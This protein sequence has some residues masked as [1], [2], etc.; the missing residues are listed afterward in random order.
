MEVSITK[1][2]IACERCVEIC[3]DVFQMGDDYAEVDVSSIPG[4]QEDTVQEAA[5]ECPVDA[6]IIE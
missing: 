6:I 1:E 2:C 3:P 4:K 5:D